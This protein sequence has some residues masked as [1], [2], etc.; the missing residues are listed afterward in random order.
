[1]VPK[2][3]TSLWYLGDMYPHPHQSPISFPISSLLLHLCCPLRLPPALQFQIPLLPSL[4]CNPRSRPPLRLQ[5]QLKYWTSHDV[6][7]YGIMAA[8]GILLLLLYSLCSHR[9]L[10]RWV[11]PPSRRVTLWL[12]THQAA[13]HPVVESEDSR[14]PN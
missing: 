6:L 7:G 14:G 1:M 11:H 13:I 4:P 10:Q 12:Y 5:T 2:H 8:E 3:A 9:R